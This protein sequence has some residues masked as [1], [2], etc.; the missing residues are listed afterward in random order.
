MV[1]NIIEQEVDK[2]SY[3]ETEESRFCLNAIQLLEFNLAVIR[4]TLDK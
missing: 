3:R 2:Y 1:I 4:Y